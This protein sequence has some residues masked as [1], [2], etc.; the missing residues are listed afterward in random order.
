MA[1]LTKRYLLFSGQ[2]VENVV[3]RFPPNTAGGWSN[4]DG[5][6]D[7][8]DAAIKTGDLESND[9]YQVVDLMTLKV[10]AGGEYL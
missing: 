7:T 3:G 5:L 9:W 8:V 1:I 2:W 10:V 4:F 6:F